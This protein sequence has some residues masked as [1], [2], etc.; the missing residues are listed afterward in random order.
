MGKSHTPPV[1]GSL[2]DLSNS[3]AESDQVPSISKH[4]V[5]KKK[6]SGAI[7]IDSNEE[8]TKCQSKPPKKVAKMPKSK[9]P[10]KAS[11]DSEDDFSDPY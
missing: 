1:P 5:K 8:F 3:E 6:K 9:C 11:G 7:L 2:H 10:R 4:V